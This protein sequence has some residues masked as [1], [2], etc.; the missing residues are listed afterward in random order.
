MTF[1][2]TRFQRSI[3][4]ETNAQSRT[5][6]NYIHVDIPLLFAILLLI[7]LGLVI[8]YSASTKNMVVLDNQL[9]RIGISL[10]I[11]FVFA[12]IPPIVYQRWAIWLYLLGVILLIGVLIF[13]HVGKGA[14]RWLNLGFFRIQPSEMMKLAIPMALAWYF[15]KI[16]LPLSLKSIGL[17]AV[18]I[19][20]PAL[21]A[22]KQPDFGTAIL[23]VAAGGSVLFLAGLSWRFMGSIFALA[24]VSAP[25]VWYFMHDY[26]KQR[27]LTFLNPEHDPLGTGYHIIQSKIAIG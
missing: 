13:G 7:S 14:E 5:F 25:F 16:H 17:A 4:R 18:I 20:I 2:N 27:V 8:L 11:M 23:L 22:A 26:Q 6:W 9:F 15:H 21:L 19:L 1:T 12:Q 3:S 10:I 24:A